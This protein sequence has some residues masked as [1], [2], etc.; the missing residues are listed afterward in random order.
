M[1]FQNFNTDSAGTM[2]YNMIS[3]WLPTY[4]LT[5]AYNPSVD[6]RTFLLQISNRFGGTSDYTSSVGFIPNYVNENLAPPV[7]SENRR[8]I[9]RD[10][11]YAHIVNSSGS[12]M[13]I[14]SS[15]GS[16]I[17]L[18]GGNG[19]WFATVNA[20]QTVVARMKQNSS[21]SLVSVVSVHGLVDDPLLV[22]N[23][24]ADRLCNYFS[25]HS[26]GSAVIGR[27]LVSSTGTTYYD[28]HPQSS[29]NFSAVCAS[30]SGDGSSFGAGGGLWAS[31]IPWRDSTYQFCIGTIPPVV[32]IGT[33]AYTVGS[34]YK[35]KNVGSGQQN[36]NAYDRY[37]RCAHQL[38][39]D[40]SLVTN[41]YVLFQVYYEE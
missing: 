12:Q 6:M 28:I 37:Y 15:V 39:Y 26:M 17:P 41:K 18:T 29:L 8:F 33:G 38:Y 21:S 14:T 10:D 35:I 20:E 13:T 36:L 1:P 32:L 7:N 9:L 34:I 2:F 16:H 24:S 23:L 11:G 30:D 40:G 25:F 27:R 19:L 31:L 22:N 5:Q 4:Y 3:P